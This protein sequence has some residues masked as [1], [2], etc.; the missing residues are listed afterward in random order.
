[1]DLKQQWE[2]IGKKYRLFIHF[3]NICLQANP[4]IPDIDYKKK[5]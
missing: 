1:M 4:Y 2:I 5:S 3:Q